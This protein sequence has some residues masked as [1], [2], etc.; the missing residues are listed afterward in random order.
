MVTEDFAATEK[1]LESLPSSS[2]SKATVAS[3][4]KATTAKHS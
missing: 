1:E 2:P 3:Q 4:S